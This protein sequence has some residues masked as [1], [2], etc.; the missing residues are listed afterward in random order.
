MDPS[1]VAAR[2]FGTFGERSQTQLLMV[3][4]LLYRVRH[5]GDSRR[6][7]LKHEAMGLRY[8]RNCKVIPA[9]RAGPH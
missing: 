7:S 4:Q 8:T 1:G 6:A 5:P 2:T 9:I 3:W